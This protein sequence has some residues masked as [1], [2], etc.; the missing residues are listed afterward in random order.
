M[1]APSKQGLD[2]FPFPVDFFD[3]EIIGGISGMFGIKGEIV[4]VKLLCTVYRKGYFAVWSDLLQAKIANDAS[5]SKDLA[6]Q[7]V[8][9]L[10]AWDFFNENLYNSAKV[11]TSVNI[12]Q[13]YLEATKRRKNRGK[14]P[15]L[16]NEDNNNG[17]N[18]VNV[19]INP[20]SKGVNDDI[21]SQ[22][23]VN[24]SKVNKTKDHHQEDDDAY[25]NLIAQFQQ[26][27]GI[28]ST[29]PLM[30]EDLRYT[31]EDFTSQGTSYSDAVEIVKYALT[32]AVAHQ[33]S[34]WSYVKGIIKTWLGNSLFDMAHIKDYQERR[35][36]PKQ[37]YGRYNQKPKETGTDWSQVKAKETANNPSDLQARLA[38]IRGKQDATN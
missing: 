17:S 6:N 19:N 4:V 38:K 2:Y 26:N 11:L 24:K 29:K 33:G 9:R 10:V 1:A 7:V 3:N 14:M 16:I 28:N 32:I 20:S 5:V 12:Q 22:S 25:K 34:S 36:K 35:N 27:F 15:Y 21:N 13:T 18:E 30:Q 31:L 8:D 23:K 37:K